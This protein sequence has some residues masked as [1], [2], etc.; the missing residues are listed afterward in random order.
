VELTLYRIIQEALTNAVKH[1]RA[2]RV[3]ISVGERD[4]MLRARIEDDGAGFDLDAET[5]GFGLMG[6]RERVA[7]LGGRLEVSSSQTGTAV[8]ATL[9]ARTT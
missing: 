6:M 9:P 2:D 1:A 3:Q 7:L 5:S 4:G 8:I